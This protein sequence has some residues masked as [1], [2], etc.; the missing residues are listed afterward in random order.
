MSTS[1]SVPS[2]HAPSPDAVPA[3]V[4]R[5]II[6]H[7]C[8]APSVYNTQP[9]RWRVR[10]G[11]FD[12]YA[13]HQ[14]RL[15]V[16]D[17]TG[18]ELTI[19][20]GAALH[21]AIVATR[22]LGWSPD[23]R[24]FPDPSRPALLA[25]VRLRRAAPTPTAAA[26]LAAIRDRATDRRRFTSWPV[27]EE[28][29]EELAR[30]ARA[31]GTEAVA[32]TD[33]TDRFRIELLVSRALQLQA[34]DPEIAAEQQQWLDRRRG[35]DGVPA[36]T[37]PDRPAPDESHRSR[38]GVGSLEDD[39]RDVEGTDGLVV[40]CDGRDD[41]ESWLRAGEGLSAL[42]L[43]AVRTGLSVVPLSQV[44]EV[45][46]TRAGLR[47]DVFGGLLE[48]L[49]LVR[50]GWQAISRRQAPQTPRRPLDDVLLP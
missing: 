28:R 35:Q 39:G 4:V 50:V 45:P 47:H 49:L 9:W 19:S 36:A 11:G 16:A 30:Q 2:V 32:V 6:R 1:S 48:P 40:I 24:R 22:A 33:V 31:W 26:D 29:L 10:P 13:D 27:P 20:C 8:E 18:R 25:E 15:A 41:V 5:R 38:F 43:H 44:V 23:V 12:L 34:R 37:V 17:P 46:E 42:W 7:A 21:H 14:R 3:A